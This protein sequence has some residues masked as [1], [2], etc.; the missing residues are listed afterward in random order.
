METSKIL[1]WLKEDVKN[2][3]KKVDALEENLSDKV[4]ALDEKLSEKIDDIAVDV[5]SLTHFQNKLVG[6][7]IAI[8]TLVSVIGIYINY[9]AMKP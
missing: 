9:L 2:V 5:K 6:V 8:S 1:D 7:A 4:H 3:D